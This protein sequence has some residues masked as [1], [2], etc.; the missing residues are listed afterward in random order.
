MSNVRYCPW[1]GSDQRAEPIPEESLLKG[2]YGKWEKGD[3][4]QYG[5]HT[6][7]VEVP[8]VYDGALYEMCPDC[9]ERWHY[10]PASNTYMRAKAEPY[11]NDKTYRT[12]SMKA[13]RLIEVS[14]DVR[15]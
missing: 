2:Y 13:P 11:V 14:A 10:W 15:Y 3:P 9:G 7:L 4:P 6:F 12:K 5:W 1:C 8:E